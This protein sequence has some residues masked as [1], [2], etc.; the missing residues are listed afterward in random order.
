M[1][2]GDTEYKAMMNKPFT[3]DTVCE[4]VGG[5]LDG[6]K[7]KVSD[8]MKECEVNG[9]H[10]DYSE[11]RKKMISGF[12]YCPHTIFDNAPLVKGYIGPMAGSPDAPLR[13]ETQGVY[14]MMSI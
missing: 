10:E 1:K 7:I 9:K 13:Y 12:G 5:P 8:V 4:F 11:M 3:D 6:R 2:Y 14:D